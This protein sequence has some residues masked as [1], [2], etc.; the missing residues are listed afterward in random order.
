MLEDPNFTRYNFENFMRSLMAYG[1]CDN[2]DYD[3]DYLWED[4]RR[5]VIKGAETWA[6]KENSWQC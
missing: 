1:W 6:G 4:Q 3:S 2:D 5:V